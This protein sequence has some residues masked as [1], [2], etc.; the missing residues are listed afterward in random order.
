[1]EDMPTSG[2][3]TGAFSDEFSPVLNTSTL[4]P[5]V[6]VLISVGLRAAETMHELVPMQ[7]PSKHTDKV[8][9][10]SLDISRPI[11]QAG[12]NS[13]ARCLGT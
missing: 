7:Q 10:H 6:H 13:H 9:G 4:V 12:L 3:L 11:R 5:E 1:M 8:P 2:Q